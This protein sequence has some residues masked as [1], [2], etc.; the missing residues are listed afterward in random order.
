MQQL[1]QPPN[2]LRM[3]ADQL[4]TTLIQQIQNGDESFLRVVSAVADAYRQEHTQAETDQQIIGY[5][6]GKGMTVREL[7]SRVAT[8]EDQIDRGDYL[9][10]EQL[11]KETEEWLSS[12]E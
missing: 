9:T 8:A 7:K 4:R 2:Y 12:I 3:G 6:A 10:P 11:E 1:Y 5:R